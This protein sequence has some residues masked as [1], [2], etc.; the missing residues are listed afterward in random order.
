LSC[1]GTDVAI[2]SVD[3]HVFVFS[4]G[5]LKQIQQ[6]SSVTKEVATAPVTSSLDKVQM[7]ALTS[8]DRNRDIRALNADAEGGW[9]RLDLGGGD[10]N[11]DL[12][13]YELQQLY[14][15]L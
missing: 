5:S 4:F 7:G 15:A 12:T 2:G 13:P 3:G 9:T 11:G 14:D 10:I 8:H 6:V 1:S